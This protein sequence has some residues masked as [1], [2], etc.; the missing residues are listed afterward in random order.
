MEAKAL[1]VTGA[2]GERKHAAD[3]EDWISCSGDHSVNNRNW[4]STIASGNDKLTGQK[5][6]KVIY[7]YIHTH[8][9]ILPCDPINSFDIEWS[10]LRS[11]GKEGKGGEEG[12]KGTCGGRKRQHQTSHT[13]TRQHRATAPSTVFFLSFLL[14][15][16]T[17]GVRVN[18][19]V[20]HYHCIS[21]SGGSPLLPWLVAARRRGSWPGD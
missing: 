15:R 10:V 5:H 12:K 19:R 4:S 14:F 6:S 7:T 3:I 11:G 17:F 21:G 1:T 2:T 8:K 16:P 20:R 18:I 13:E 9:K